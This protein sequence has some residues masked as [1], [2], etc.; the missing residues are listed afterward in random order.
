MTED[1]SMAVYGRNAGSPEETG[2]LRRALMKDV[3]PRSIPRLWCPLLTHYWDDG[4]IHFNRMSVHL[5]R[6]A[7]W[8]KGYLIPGSTGDGWELSEDETLQVL[9]FAVDKAKEHDLVLLAGV[10]RPDPET[11]MK[12]LERMLRVLKR[13]SGMEDT[14]E[15][16]KATRVLAFAFCPPAGKAVS[17]E[18]I[19]AHYEAI[20]DRG[21]PVA[22]YQL[23]QVTENEVDT[24][25]FQT[26]LSQYPNLVFL[27]DSSGSDRLASAPGDKEGLFLVRGAE[28]DYLRWIREGGGP[29]DG[30]LLSTANCFPQHLASIIENGQRGELAGARKLS[31]TLSRCIDE[32]FAVVRHL[33]RGNA[34]TN[35]NKAMD[36]FL[37]YGASADPKR[38]PVLHA[39]MRLPEEVL[40]ATGR[41]LRRHGLMAERGYL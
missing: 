6:L 22:L 5:A 3:F 38:G 26:L 41:I 36:H 18:A 12:T 2:L 29:Y 17:R 40:T 19:A 39:G 37:A 32:I 24:G 15:A 7:P 31:D 8:V 4:S 9:Q 28:G 10:L 23:P 34:F 21:F 35:A 33:P 14:L 27:K 11:T 25:T 13:M 20:L 30:L 16:M 1:P